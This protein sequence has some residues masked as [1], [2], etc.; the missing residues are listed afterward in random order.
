[1]AVLWQVS[2]VWNQQGW[3]QDQGPA[4]RKGRFAWLHP[5]R[6]FGVTYQRSP[7]HAK[8]DEQIHPGFM[9]TSCV[10]RQRH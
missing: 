10:P 9:R 7:Q 6:R 1:M 8:L 2:I 4:V 3:T 5:A